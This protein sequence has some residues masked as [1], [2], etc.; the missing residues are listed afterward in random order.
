MAGLRDTA[1]RSNACFLVDNLANPQQV[2]MLQRAATKQFAPNLWTGIGGKYEGEESLLEGVQRELLEETGLIS[3]LVEFARCS[4]NNEKALHY[5]VGIADPT[6][7]PHCNEGA[8]AWVNTK[9]I[10]DREIIPTTRFVLEEWARRGF[11][12]DRPFTVRLSRRDVHDAGST[13]E[14]VE[15]DEGLD[16]E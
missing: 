6:V 8:V 9:S 15:I 7:T 14:H 5:F 10:F 11:L 12:S 4:I 1:Q 3:Q 2:L 16:T 13:W